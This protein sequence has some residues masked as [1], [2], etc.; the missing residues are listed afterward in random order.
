MKK[1]ILGASV[2]LSLL[3]CVSETT[4]AGKSVSQ[5]MD[6][7]GAAKARMQLGIQYL[8]QGNTEQAKFNLERALAYNSKDP[9]IHRALAYYYEVV[10]EPRQA[11]KAYRQAL[12]IN[13]NDADTMNNYGTFLCREKKY[14]E[15]EE[16]FLRAVKETTYVRVGDTYENAGLCARESGQLDKALEYFDSALS[17]SPRRPLSLLEMAGIHVTQENYD[18]ARNYLLQYQKVASDT[19]QSLW[20]W[21]RLESAQNR[22]T[23]VKSFGRRLVNKFPQSTES[24]HYLKNEY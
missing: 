5:N 10:N 6:S 20:T 22:E 8:Q 12:S 2:L 11:E 16:Q 3:G 18:V 24:Q 19:P 21:I 17:H 7:N 15:A 13:R 4:V 23:A 14:A 1:L 9:E